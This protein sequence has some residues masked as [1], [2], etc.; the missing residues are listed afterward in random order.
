MLEYQKFKG[1]KI[2]IQISQLI[3]LLGNIIIIQKQFN[4]KSTRY[5]NKCDIKINRFSSYLVF[6]KNH[7]YVL[8]FVHPNVKRLKTKK[9]SIRCHSYYLRNSTLIL[10]A[11]W[12]IFNMIFMIIL[13]LWF[14][15][16]E[17]AIGLHFIDFDSELEINEP[18]TVK[19][20]INKLSIIKMKKTEDYDLGKI[21]QWSLW[22][23]LRIIWKN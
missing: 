18:I 9:Y 2:Y 20:I 11:K 3:L 10:L 4:D 15:K 8:I 19:D 22:I 17:N 5:D 13:I 16:R 1:G 14:P 23:T 12:S 6:L 21:P 7:S